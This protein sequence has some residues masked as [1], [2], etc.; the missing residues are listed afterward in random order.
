MRYLLTV[1]AFIMGF[2]ALPV[3]AMNCYAEH[4][5]GN[6]VVIGYVPRIAIPSDGKKGDKIWQSSEYFM[7][8]FC[9]NALPAPSPGEE[10]P[11]AWVN[12]M[13]LLAS[14]QD[15]YNQN[16]YT[17]G[18]TYN[19]VDYDSTSTRAIAAPECID[20]KGAG[21]YSN[22]YK[23][24]AVCSGDP[25]PQLSVTFPVRVQLYIKLAK[26]AN[27]VN[28]KLVLPDEYIA[29][30]F[31]GMSGTGTIDTD[32]NLTFRIRGLNNIHVLDCFVNVDL[33]PAD[34]VVDF[35]KI[36]SR[37]IKNTSVSETFSVVM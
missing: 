3:W 28:K 1:I 35:G 27:K 37:T 14:G 4:E 25:E 17:L 10:Y 32:K 31:K 22:T 7:N 36:N 19:G 6:T 8:V 16:S 33:E 5:G 15:F 11:S 2:S 23:N 26:N 9:N 24:P 12:I 30:E 13:M 20:V 21:I 29:L 34:G 18:V